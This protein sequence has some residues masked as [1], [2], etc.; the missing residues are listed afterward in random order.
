MQHSFFEVLGIW[1][2]VLCFDLFVVYIFCRI[3]RDKNS[4]DIDIDLDL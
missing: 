1:S 2:I 4:D 3:A